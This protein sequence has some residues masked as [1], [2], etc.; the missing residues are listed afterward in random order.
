M[1]PSPWMIRTTGRNRV[2]NQLARTPVA[3]PRRRRSQRLQT[4]F[5]L[6][7][8]TPRTGRRPKVRPVSRRTVCEVTT[9]WLGRSDWSRRDKRQW[10][11]P[12]G[13]GPIGGGGDSPLTHRP[14][15]YRHD[16]CGRA[17]QISR[18]RHRSARAQTS[19]FSAAATG[20]K[21]QLHRRRFARCAGEDALAIHACAIRGGQ[22][23]PA[24]YFSR[25]FATTLIRKVSVPSDEEGR[26]R[27]R[28]GM[29]P[30]SS[31]SSTSNPSASKA[32]VISRVVRIT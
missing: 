28:S 16:V 17:D 21:S 8:L 29:P 9:V 20:A 24:G 15:G 14:P 25:L 10:E 11:K 18:R 27:S 3:N 19:R 23:K 22:S 12:L 6:F 1:T 31:T 26:S 2:G 13:S 30:P 4:R 7:A 32:S 5:T